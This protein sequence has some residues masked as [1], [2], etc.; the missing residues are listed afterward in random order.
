MSLATEPSDLSVVRLVA[1]ALTC[2]VYGAGSLQQGLDWLMLGHATLESFGNARKGAASPPPSHLEEA[3]GDP[4]EGMAVLELHAS[5]E[6]GLRSCWDW[7]G[8][9]PGTSTRIADLE[10]SKYS[11]MRTSNARILLV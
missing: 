1:R 8:P 7:A 2:K 11:V 10:Q 5:T 9:M 6:A 3:A 4:V